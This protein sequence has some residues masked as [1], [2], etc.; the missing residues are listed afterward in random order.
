MPVVNLL[1]TPTARTGALGPL[2]VTVFSDIPTVPLLTQIEEAQT[3]HAAQSGN[4]VLLCNVVIAP[5]LAP[6]SAE[7]REFSSQ[8]Q[9]RLEAFTVGSATVLRMGGLSAVLARG[10]MAGLALL[11]HTRHPTSVFK[12]TDEAVTWLLSLPGGERLAREPDVQ[13]QVRAY[14]AG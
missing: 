1:T 8:M 3:R 4:Q 12:E 11:R 5:K 9:H 10:F 7:V 13:A 2:I 14:V 6:P